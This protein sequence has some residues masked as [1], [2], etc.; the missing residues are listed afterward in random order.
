MLHQT[1]KIKELYEDIQRKLYYMIPEKLEELYLY[2]SIFDGNKE[3]KKGELFF[4][5]IPKGIFRKKPVNVYEIPY[6]FNLDEKQYLKLVRN[7]YAKIKELR[8][9]FKKVEKKEVWSNLTIIIK[10]LKFKVEY[11]YTDL[12]YAEFNNY[13]RHI[14]WRYENL[15]IGEEQMSKEDKKILKRYFLGARML[16]RKEK[17]EAGIYIQDIENVVAYSTKNDKKEEE[18]EIKEERRKETEEKK[19]IHKNQLL[20]F[21]NQIAKQNNQNK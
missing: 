15:G 18:K 3:E 1:K 7:L 21:Q 16:Q 11:D 5:Y 12:D 2:S 14:I 6:K 19:I 13:E 8:I 10:N 4:Y 9:E 17:Y 20:A